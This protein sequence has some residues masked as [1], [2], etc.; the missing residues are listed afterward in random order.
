MPRNA[1]TR[2]G[3]G[4]G[5]GAGWGGPARGA[6]RGGAARAYTAGCPTRRTFP[7]GQGDPGKRVA[8]DE[9][10]ASRAATADELRAHLSHLAFHAEREETQLS[11]AVALLNRIEGLPVARNVNLA[12]DDLSRLTDAELEAEIARLN[13]R[14]GRIG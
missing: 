5:Q 11:A 4:I 6:G 8:R 7:G 9:E 2:L 1:I 13:C 12:V 10:R 14:A 3:N